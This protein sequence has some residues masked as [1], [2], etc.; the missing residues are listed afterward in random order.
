MLKESFSDSDLLEGILTDSLSQV[1]ED[2][3]REHLESIP[4]AV[5]DDLTVLPE[6]RGVAHAR[7]RQLKFVHLGL[8][9]VLLL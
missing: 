7:L 4:A 9:P 6:L 8:E 2:H 3:V 1:D 5:D